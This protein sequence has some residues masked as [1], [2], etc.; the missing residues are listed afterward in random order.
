[1]KQVFTKVLLAS[2]L[3]MGLTAGAAQAQNATTPDIKR[4]ETLFTQGDVQR[5]ILACVACHGQAG[6]S[7]IAMYPH[8]A[9]M[10]AGYIVSQL[11]N[12]Q[13]AEG[14]DRSARMNIDGSPTAMAP[15]VAKMTEQDMNDLAAYISKQKLSKPAFAQH[16]ADIAFVHRGREIWRAGIP[17]R[18]VPACASCHG[19]EGQGM[20]EQFPFLSGQHPEYI[21]SQLHSFAEGARTH[22]GAENMMGTIANRMSN[23]DMKAVADYAAGIR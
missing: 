15:I 13:V 2:G 12:F 7:A 18:H 20:P 3:V 16:A 22:G 19:A 9:G 10:P 21:L 4:G 5:G 14:A 6:T 8:L 17:E 1:M 23:A 11:K